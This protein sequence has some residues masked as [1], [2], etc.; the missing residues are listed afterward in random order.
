MTSYKTQEFETRLL[1][2]PSLKCDICGSEDIVED[3][4]AYVC[5]DCG[6][7]LKIQKLQYDRPYNNDMIQHS[8]HVGVTQVGTIWERFTSK[9]SVQIQR[10][11][12]RQLEQSSF[13]H[14]KHKIRRK[15]SDLCTKLQ[16]HDSKGDLKQYIYNK[17]VEVYKSFRSG[18]KYRSVKKLVPVVMYY[19][20]KFRNI[21]RPET[22]FIDNSE[23]TKKEFNNFKLQVKQFLP[24]YDEYNRQMVILQKI[25]Y[26]QAEFNLDRAFEL[27]TRKILYKLWNLIKN[28]KDD[29]VAGFCASISALCSYQN[30]LNVNSICTLLGIRMSTIQSQVKRNFF[31]RFKVEGFISLVKSSNLLVDIMKKLGILEGAEEICDIIEIKLGKTRDVFNIHDSVD[32]YLFAIKDIDNNVVITKLSEYKPY[33]YFVTVKN[34]NPIDLLQL[35]MVLSTYSKGKDPPFNSHFMNRMKKELLKKLIAFLKV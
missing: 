16:L 31:E 14:V 6:I 23:I 3:R 18:T 33:Q 2:F 1:E 5:R 9:L 13:E 27:L 19:S 4:S 32:Y 25:S 17:C 34:V 30:R 10:I 22:D 24:K 11:N 35:T 29:V 26:I 20:L 21:S 7:V 8:P 28:T 15:V 12:K